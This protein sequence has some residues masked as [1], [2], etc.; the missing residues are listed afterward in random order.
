MGSNK[1]YAGSVDRAMD[2]RILQRIASE[3][4]PLQTLTREE[5]GLDDTPVTIDPHPNG[6][7]RSCTD[8]HPEQPSQRSAL[9][10]LRSGA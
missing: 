1:R 9:A 2:A 7:V 3:A 4:G 5:I 10:Y 8:C 6:I